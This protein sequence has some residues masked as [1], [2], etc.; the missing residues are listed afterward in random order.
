MSLVRYLGASEEYKSFRA[1]SSS[2]WCFQTRGSET[3]SPLERI[4][5][6]FASSSKGGGDN[7]GSKLSANVQEMEQIVGLALKEIK[8]LTEEVSSL[9]RKLCEA[10]QKNAVDLQSGSQA[11]M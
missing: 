3:L 5:H 6:R 11:D 1:S 10:K 7:T 8:N 4:Y 2:P 9:G